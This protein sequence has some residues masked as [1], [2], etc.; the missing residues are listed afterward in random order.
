MIMSTLSKMI[1]QRQILTQ[2]GEITTYT[3][4]KREK[5]LVPPTVSMSSKCQCVP[6]MSHD[7]KY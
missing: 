6:Q 3:R 5:V 2:I 7:L 4:E 1:A